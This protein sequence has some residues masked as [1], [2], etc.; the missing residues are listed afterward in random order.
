MMNEVHEASEA[1]AR[2]LGSTVIGL[3]AHVHDHGTSTSQAHYL[4]E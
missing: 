2:G 3:N 1:K 4:H